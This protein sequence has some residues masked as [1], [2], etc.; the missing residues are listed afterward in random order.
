MPETR[1]R[2]TGVWAFVAIVAVC[3]L[4]AG[5]YVLAGALGGAD[6]PAP[7]KVGE[8]AAA[9]S[10]VPPAGQDVVV[11]R[12]LDRSG[13]AKT[14]GRLAWAPL[15]APARPPVT[16]LNRERGY[17]GSGHAMSLARHD[18][19]PVSYRAI[20]LDANLKVTKE[21]KLGGVPSRSRISPSGH[22]A[23][24]TTFVSGHSYAVPGAFSTA[25]IIIDL[26]TGRSLG[27]LEKTFAIFRGGRRLDKPDINVWGVTFA[28]DDDTFYATVG[29][30]G[31]TYLWKGSIKRR[32]GQVIHENVECPSLSPDGTRI[33]YKKL[34][35]KLGIWRFTVLD[36]ATMKETP[37]AETR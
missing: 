1:A 17:L 5:G 29:T 3:V 34:V 30:G 25:T 9:R 32:N 15:S 19:F 7:P 10:A 22:W 26:R 13:G 8:Q 35:G 2:N 18:G 4:G 21:V 36:L 12:S 14:Y 23:S 28:S 20:V 16:P 37:L 33:G 11:F 6:E 31:K 24:A 27:N